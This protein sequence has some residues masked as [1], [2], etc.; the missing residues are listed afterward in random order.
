[1]KKIT[2]RNAWIAFSLALVVFLA[3]VFVINWQLWH[4]DQATHVASA[5]QAAKKIAVIIDEARAATVT[6]LNVSRSGCSVQGQFQLGTETALQPHLRTILLI[7]DGQVW[8]SSLP[9][10]RVL[11]LH[12]ESLSVEPLLLLPARMM[13]N[14]RPVLI[15]QTHSA[16][17]RVIVTISDV[18]LRDALYSDTDND[19]LVLWV[20]HQMIARYGDVESL[21]AGPHQGIFSSPDYPFRII[22]PESPFFSPGRLFH[23]GFGLLIF[24]F[25]VS[26]LF[27]FLLRKYLNV[28]TSEEENLRYAIAQGDIVPYYQPVVNGKTGEIYGVEILARWKNTTAQWRSPAEF[29]PLAERTGLIIPL[30][31]SLMA[32]VAAQMRPIFSKLPDGFHI[33]LNISA[34]HINAP[35]FIDDCLHYQRGFEGKA[36]KLMLEITEQEPLLLNGAV[37]DKLKTLHSRG[38]SIALDDFGTGYSGLSYLHELVFDYI[39]IDQSFVG[40]VTGETPS[41]KLLDCV[42]EMARTLSLRIIAEGVETQAQLDY[43]NRQNIHLLQGYYFW[44]PMPYVALVML[45]LSKPKA[46]IVEE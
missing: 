35:T 25:S 37:V 45:L 2:V 20:N 26:L 1:M 9:G 34:S 41:S 44:K 5:R 11:T 19:G 28:Y 6:A 22:Y 12:P 7:K 27:Y 31:R 36:V 40:R 32:Q 21:N 46:R 3:G 8:C 15:Y 30:T 38:F 17:I 16:Q 10:N 33:G 13:V 24:I 39:K 23:N 43:L 4:S 42:I 14:K 18:H 29:I